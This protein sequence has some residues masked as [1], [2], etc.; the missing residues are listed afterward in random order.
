MRISDWSSDVCSSDLD[1][2]VMI[3]TT[4]REGVEILR[5]HTLVDEVLPCGRGRRDGAHRRDVVSRYAVGQQHQRTGADDILGWR[6]LGA[7]FQKEGRL[8]HVVV[9]RPCEGVAA[10]GPTILPAAVAVAHRRIARLVTLR[11]ANAVGKTVELPGCR[12]SNG[13]ENGGPG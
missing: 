5:R 4:G 6:P 13:P 9:V 11:H 12:P 2:D 7:D 3:H 10:G 1:H 8:L